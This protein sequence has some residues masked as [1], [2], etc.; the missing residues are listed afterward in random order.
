MPAP[1]RQAT[2]LAIALAAFP[3]AAF[4]AC[5]ACDRRPPIASCDD[6]LRGVYVAG[7][8]RWMLLDNGPTLEAYPLFSDGSITSD[9]V[10]APR[11][12]DLERGTRPGDPRPG[13]SPPGGSPADDAPSGNL[14]PLMTGMV[15]GTLH[16]RFMRRA[17]RCDAHVPVVVT[18][19]AG[20]RLELVLGDPSPPIAFAPCAWAQPGPS[21]I[22]RW[23]R[24]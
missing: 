12:I 6:D 9:F 11:V 2:A 20:D 16:Q 1:R 19:C 17:E 21:R 15:R 22:V 13:D 8:E 7:N 3:F 4:A 5:A 18:R 24:E 10:V 23:Q 14:K